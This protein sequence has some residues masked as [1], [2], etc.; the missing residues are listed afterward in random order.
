MKA[1]VFYGKN[2][3]NIEEKDIP[4]AKA[5]EVV[6]K[7]MACGVCER[8]FIFSTVTRAR[9]QHRPEQRS[10]TNFREW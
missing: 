6:I 3:L 1:A 8:I 9:R 4:K 10:V 2:N 5:D 7:V